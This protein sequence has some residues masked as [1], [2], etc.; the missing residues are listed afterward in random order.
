MKTTILPSDS[1]EEEEKGTWNNSTKP[2]EPNLHNLK[3][4]RMRG[5]L[6]NIFYWQR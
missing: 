6:Q 5:D 1:K 3:S 4:W 2:D